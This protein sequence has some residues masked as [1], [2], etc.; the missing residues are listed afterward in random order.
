MSEENLNFSNHMLT[1]RAIEGLLGLFEGDSQFEF[2]QKNVAPGLDDGDK[3]NLRHNF[4][5]K[6][7]LREMILKLA[8]S[9]PLPTIQASRDKDR[10][11]NTER[12]DLDTKLQAICNRR[13]WEGDNTFMA[14]LPW[15]RC[16]AFVTGDCFVK[17]PTEPDE[18]G[19]EGTA[20]GMVCY[21]ER[22][23]S[24]KTYIK[25]HSDIRKKIIG[26]RFQYY[27]GSGLYTE[28]GDLALLVTEYIE[29][30]LW[31]LDNPLDKGG[32][33]T[34]DTNGILCVSHMAWE[35]RE[36][37]ARGVPLALRLMDKILH[38]QSIML[39]RR[40]GNKMGSVPMYA[41][42]NAQGDPPPI[43]PGST[44]SLKTEVPW[45]EAKIEAVASKFDDQSLQREYKDAVRELYHEAML[46]FEEDRES[47][48]GIGARSGKA[49]QMLSQDMIKYREAYQEKETSFLQDL[50]SKTLTLEG[51]DCD[52]NDIQIKYPSL[53][54]PDATDRLADAT[55]FWDAGLR[56]KSLETM[57]MDEDEAIKALQDLDD[58][59]AQ[60]LL[61][62]G[63]GPQFDAE[64]KPLPPMPV[65]PAKPG[66]VPM[67]IQK[68]QPPKA[69]AATKSVGGNA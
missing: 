33:K 39:D 49:L 36:E 8:W 12:K 2:W 68:P 24:Q 20:N 58:A 67:P 66:D 56:E 4:P 19:D 10:L 62:Q 27:L 61:E 3:K 44:W 14:A 43:A 64:G 55:F 31:T 17:L 34:F 26:Y 22:M 23:P 32:K 11:T 45:A 41:V 65:P 53:I 13:E 29:E 54:T 1:T 42:Y 38:I 18:D 15:W 59:A 51:T 46:P 6:N 35:E 48:S 21:P 9:I 40:L 37:S 63:P 30:N 57:D 52:P 16:Y 69:V 5:R 7:W 28:Q 47:S 60:K 50:F 25:M